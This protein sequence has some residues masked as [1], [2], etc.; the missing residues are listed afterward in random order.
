F[1][2]SVKPPSSYTFVGFSTHLSD[3]AEGHHTAGSRFVSGRS[4]DSV[5]AVGHLVRSVLPIPVHLNQVLVVVPS[6]CTPTPS[7]D[8]QQQIGTTTMKEGLRDVVNKL[9]LC[10]TL[11][12]RR[13]VPTFHDA[14]HVPSQHEHGGYISTTLRRR[15]RSLLQDGV[16]FDYYVGVRFG[17][18]QH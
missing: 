17:F 2:S 10:L 12:L 7:H 18:V 15:C 9:R 3:A 13:R 6:S 16:R 5:V 14:F 8:A 4:Q 11:N 1:N